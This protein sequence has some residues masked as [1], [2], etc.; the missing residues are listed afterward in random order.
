MNEYILPTVGASGYYTL[1]SPLDTLIST[2]EKYTC[3]AIRRISDYLANNEDVFKDIY[4]KNNISEE[5]FKADVQIDMYIVSLQSEIGHWL[6]IPAKYIAKYPIVNGIPYRTVSIAIALPA[7]PVD[8]ELSH[9]VTDIGNIITDA[10]GVNSSI[11]IV[12]TSRVVL[13]DKTK[14]DLSVAN[15]TARTNGR[16]TD[17]SRYTALSS[18][19]QTIVNQVVQLENYIKSRL[20]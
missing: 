1:I 14:H 2:N 9:I 20:P 4:Q 10:L 7:L 11:S 3:Q 19:Y 13:V 12:E 5:D 17:R 16:V 8:Q 6:Y 18:D 15:R